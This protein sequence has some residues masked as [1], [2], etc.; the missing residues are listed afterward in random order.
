M[1]PGDP[2]EHDSLLAE[3]HAAIMARVAAGTATETDLV[4]LL[5]SITAREPQPPSLRDFARELV[6]FARRSVVAA[7]AQ[8]PEREVAR[9]QLAFTLACETYDALRLGPARYT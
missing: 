3:A 4:A 2:S 8:G 5:G 6:G 9:R 1:T 7:R